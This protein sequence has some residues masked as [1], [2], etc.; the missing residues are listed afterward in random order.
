MG[1]REWGREYGGGRGSM[2][3]LGC[4]VGKVW[5]GSSMQE[6]KER[7]WGGDRCQEG[8]QRERLCHG[9]A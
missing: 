2:G 8:A 6:P 9:G 1:G 3:G 5:G 7:W 4:K